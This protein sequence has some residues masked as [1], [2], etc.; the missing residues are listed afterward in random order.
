MAAETITS[1]QILADKIM[2]S[3]VEEYPEQAI[4]MN[5]DEMPQ[6]E[7]GETAEMQDNFKTLQA[8]YDYQCYRW[9]ADQSM[10]EPPADIN[11]ID[12]TEML[13]QIQEQFG[14]FN[15]PMPNY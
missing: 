7:E 15:M 8:D 14:N 1:H 10:F 12:Y 4:K 9:S 5:L 11:F 3:W 6:A 13:K 2:Y